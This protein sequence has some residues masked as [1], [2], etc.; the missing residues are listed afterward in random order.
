MKAAHK[1]L[2]ALTIGGGGNARAGGGGG[3]E[4]KEA[5]KPPAGRNTQKWHQK[6]AVSQTFWSKIAK[7]TVFCSIVPNKIHSQDRF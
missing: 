7:N 4:L 3:R 6:R 2:G 1:L 5:N